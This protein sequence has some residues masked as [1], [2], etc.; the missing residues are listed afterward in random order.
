[1]AFAA[2]RAHDLC[3]TTAKQGTLDP[4]DRPVLS[5]VDSGRGTGR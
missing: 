3:M 2:H 4:A 1:M 5:D